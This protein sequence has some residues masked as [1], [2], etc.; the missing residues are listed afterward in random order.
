MT[1]TPKTIDVEGIINSVTGESK[2][3]PERGNMDIDIPQ[4]H[5]DIITND[6]PKEGLWTEFSS[7]LTSEQPIVGRKAYHI[8]NDVIDT[9][10]QCNFGYPNVTVINA[11]LRTFLEAN[12]AHLKNIEKKKLYPSILDRY[13]EKTVDKSGTKD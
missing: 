5:P 13:A 10:N 1:S 2:E 11:I 6:K 4:T 9:L 3:Y 12:V 7:C 8:D